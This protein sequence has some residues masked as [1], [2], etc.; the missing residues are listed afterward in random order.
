MLNDPHGISTILKKGD[1]F[2]LDRGFRDVVS[3][4]EER[5]YKVLMPAL[6]G[7]RNQLT[8]EESNFLRFVTKILW[9]VEVV[10]GIIAQKYKLLHHQF[11]NRLLPDAGT[12]CK[13]ANLLYNLFGKRLNCDSEKLSDI[14]ARMKSNRNTTNSLAEKVYNE[15]LNR[16][17]VSFQV[18]SS[19]DLLD[20]PEITTDDLKIYFGRSYQLSQAISYLGEMVEEDNSL[21]LS[22][23]KDEPE[24]VKFEVKSRHM[25]RKTYKCYIKYNANEIGID[26]I[27]GHCCNCANGLRTVGCCSHVARSDLS[28]IIWT[29]FVESF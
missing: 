28:F 18:L 24:I 16:K 17:S 19:R 26:A 20:F 9:V 5:G 21:K 27:K 10:H 3:K 25:N 7:N 22:F 6:K 14:I 8:T 1:I 2:V 11:N 12:Y 4:L 23:L 15:N 13:V 29:I